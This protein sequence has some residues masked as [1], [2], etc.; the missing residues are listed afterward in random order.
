MTKTPKIRPPLRYPGSK[1]RAYKYIEPFV[2]HAH[3]D[4][5]REPFLGSGAV[6]F[7]K[8]NSEYTL[9]NDLDE[10]LINFYKVIQQPELAARL[11]T[12]SCTFVPNKQAFEKLKNTQPITEYERALKYFLIN[13][14]AYSGIMN[15]PNWGFHTSKSVQP[16]QWGQRI[17]QAAEKIQNCKITALDYEQVLFAPAEGKKILFFIDP[18]YFSA[19]QKRAYVKSFIPIDHVRLANNLKKLPHD[20][21]LTYDDCDAVRKLY[22]WANIFSVE[23]MYHTA[24]SNVTTRK[25]GKELIITNFDL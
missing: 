23:F 7:Q 13:R 25:K 2:N 16:C 19:D 10:E 3:Y 12:E 18:P 17:I 8:M 4:E 1:Y 6:F 21:I 14:T 5:Y 20:F 11:A 24:N 15:M 22:S 9:L